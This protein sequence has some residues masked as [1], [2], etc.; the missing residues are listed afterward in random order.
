MATAP[1]CVGRPHCQ[2]HLPG[3]HRVETGEQSKDQRQSWVLEGA[4]GAPSL[5]QAF[6][7]ELQKE[8]AMFALRG[9]RRPISTKRGDL[10][11]KMYLL[12]E[13]TL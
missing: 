4:V 9:A 6:C 1:H 7:N 3:C 10:T 11:P 13:L 8:F 12:V 5:Q 2:P